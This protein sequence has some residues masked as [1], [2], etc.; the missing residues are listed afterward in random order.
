MDADGLGT[1][2]TTALPQLAARLIDLFEARGIPYALGGALAL[3][4]HAPPRGTRDIDI[5]LFLEAPQAREAFEAVRAMGVGIDPGEAVARA[6]ERGDAVGW[7]EGIRIDFF[8]NSIPLHD[9]AARRKVRVE[10]A[11]RPTWILS[12][13]DLVFLKLMFDRPKDHVDI[14]QVFFTQGDDLDRAYV[15]AQLIEH[16]G[17]DDHRVAAFDQLVALYAG[18][19]PPPPDED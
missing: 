6:S 7:Y 18:G 15:R 11:E 9:L 13:E 14:E 10:F 8:V 3:G 2:G 16:V 12:A 1:S 5:N 4:Y 17:A 19:R